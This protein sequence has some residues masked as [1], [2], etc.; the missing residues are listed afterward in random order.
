MKFPHANI[1]PIWG[2]AQVA[3]V[4]SWE[5]GKQVYSRLQWVNIIINM[6]ISSSGSIIIITI[7]VITNIIIFTIL[8]ITNIIITIIIFKIIDIEDDDVHKKNNNIKRNKNISQNSRNGIKM[9][10]YVVLVSALL[11]F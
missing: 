1:K 4:L 3:L 2:V 7:T 11:V 8:I 5:A 6:N 10:S 9:R